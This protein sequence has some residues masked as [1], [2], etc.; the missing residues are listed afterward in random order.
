MRSP[1]RRRFLMKRHERSHPIGLL[2]I[3]T[4]TLA[5]AAIYSVEAKK[6]PKW[7]WTVSIPGLAEAEYEACNLYAVSPEEALEDG[8]ITYKNNGFVDVDFWK[9][10]DDDA[11][12]VHST[13]VLTIENTDKSID[14]PGLYSI[15]FRDVRF[16]G[17]KSYCYNGGEGPCRCYVLPNYGLNGEDCCESD[18]VGPEGDNKNWV[19]TEFMESEAHPSYG[20]REFSLRFW[21][22]TDIESMNPGETR[23][24]DGYMWRLNIW[25]TGEV[26]LDGSE[27]FH[28]I[29]CDPAWPL[30]DV[31]VYRSG[32]NE[33]IITVDQNGTVPYGPFI[34]FGEMYQQG[35]E[36]TRGKS[37]KTYIDSEERYAIKAATPFKFITKWTRSK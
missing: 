9:Y 1:T 37:G 30:K 11:G 23:T 21:V 24:V 2:V 19:M 10:E 35:I 8:Y 34:I 3:L 13:F 36:K 33:W 12:E 22:Y 17:C 26:L 18:C 31:D 7:E 29:V 4:V 32:E 20:Y 15:G 25:N 5:F 14:D 16:T 6:P 27:D 28:N